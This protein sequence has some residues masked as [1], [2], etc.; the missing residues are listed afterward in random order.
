VASLQSAARSGAESAEL[1]QADNGGCGNLAPA[2]MVNVCGIESSGTKVSED[3]QRGLKNVLYGLGLADIV[4][5]KA[6]V[7][8]RVALVPPGV[9]DQPVNGIGEAG[10]ARRG[11][12]VGCSEDSQ[13][14]DDVL[15]TASPLNCHG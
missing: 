4:E 7:A 5:E 6:D 13:C 1:P 15:T 12:D 8:S 9:I 3:G 14:L 2:G 10:I 11:G